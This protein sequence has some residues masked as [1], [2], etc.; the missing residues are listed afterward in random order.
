M[1]ARQPTVKQAMVMPRNGK[2][3]HDATSVLA[4]LPDP[5]DVWRALL[6]MSRKTPQFFA[7]ALGP[8]DLR[9]TDY[10]LLQ[11]LSHARP[12][13]IAKLR[14]PLYVTKAGVKDIP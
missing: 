10:K 8:V 11:K 5:M 12:P 6:L 1:I 14:H 2:P 7:N 9:F 13:F 4:S 3:T